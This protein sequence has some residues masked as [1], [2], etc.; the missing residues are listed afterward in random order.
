[1]KFEDLVFENLE[2]GEGIRAVTFI[3]PYEISVIKSDYSY[4]GRSG[5]YEIGVWR[6]E[7]GCELPGITEEGD[8]VK[9]YLTEEQVSAILMKVASI[10]GV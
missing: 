8:T 5:L 7:K 3:G 2:F 9:G 10:S 6:D 4:G 1:M